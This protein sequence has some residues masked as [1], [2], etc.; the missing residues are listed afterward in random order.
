[1]CSFVTAGKAIDMGNRSSSFTWITPI[2]ALNNP[3][4]PGRH[5]KHNKWG[6]MVLFLQVVGRCK[7]KAQEMMTEIKKNYECDVKRTGGN[8]EGTKCQ[9]W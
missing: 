7:G 4:Y 3:S 2:Y 8:R 1:M 6:I 5:V 9:M